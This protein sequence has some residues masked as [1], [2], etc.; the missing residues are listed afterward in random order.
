MSTFDALDVQRER[1]I[2]LATFRRDGREVHTPVWFA[3]DRED[4]SRL[5]VYTNRTS[6]KVKRVRANG[7]ARVAACSAR[8][9]VTGEWIDASAGEAAH[10]GDPEAFERG[11]NAIVD[12][13]GVQMRAALFFSRIGGRYEDRTILEIRLR[14]GGDAT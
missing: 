6:G 3:A 2:S 11:M 1:Y 4:P 12:R 5:W 10:D 13:Y 7:R 14:D 9:R 8:G